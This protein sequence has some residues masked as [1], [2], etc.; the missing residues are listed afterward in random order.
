[1]D[2]LLQ[3]IQE[4][5][6]LPSK[7]PPQNTE[8]EIDIQDPG[9]GSP[10]ANRNHK[11][12]YH[13]EAGETA[14]EWP[15]GENGRRATTQTNLLW[16]VATV[17]RRQGGNSCHTPAGVDMGCRIVLTSDHFESGDQL[18]INLETVAWR[19]TGDQLEINLDGT[20]PGTLAKS[21]LS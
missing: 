13:A 5:K 9:H 3:P 7:L 21:S 4:A 15:P 1:M 17:A 19:S 14:M 6:S 11:H 10:G 20:I 18:E 8:P 2:R 12:P 16:S